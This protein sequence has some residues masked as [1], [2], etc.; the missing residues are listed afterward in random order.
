MQLSN[1]FKS[2]VFVLN[3]IAS[4]SVH[5][6]QKKAGRVWKVIIVSL[7][8]PVH[9][10]PSEMAAYCKSLFDSFTQLQV[11]SI[12]G[13]IWQLSGNK[14]NKGFGAS[15]KECLKLFL[16]FLL[17]ITCQQAG[18]IMKAAS[19]SFLCIPAGVHKVS[20]GFGEHWQLV[21]TRDHHRDSFQWL[22]LQ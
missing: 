8:I 16:I 7:R 9:W 3:G 21:S 4:N 5:V 15:E 18:E 11:S 14:V 19:L 20:E 22:Y 1:Y 17:F 13:S 12:H 2:D 10:N 6:K